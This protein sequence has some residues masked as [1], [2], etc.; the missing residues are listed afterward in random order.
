MSMEDMAIIAQSFSLVKMNDEKFWSF[1]Q[2]KLS[3]T[4]ELS[5][6]NPGVIAGICFAYAEASDP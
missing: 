2:K 3:G 1:L 6:G 4:L 5:Q